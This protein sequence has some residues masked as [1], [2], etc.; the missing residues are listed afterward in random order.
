MNSLQNHTPKQH[1]KAPPLSVGNG[2]FVRA[3]APLGIVT[4]TQV[5]LATQG[6]QRVGDFALQDTSAELLP[7]ERVCGCCRRR[8]DKTKPR[9]VKYNNERKKAH[10]ANVQR[11]GSVWI[12]PVCAKQVTEGRR[13][14]LAVGIERWKKEHSGS[15]QLLTLTFSHHLGERLSVLLQCLRKATKLFLETT[16]V[17]DLMKSAGVKYKIKS[18]EVTYGENGWHPHHHFLLLGTQGMDLSAVRDELAGLWIKACQRAGLKSPNMQHGLDVRNGDYAN[19]YVAKWGLDYEMTKGHTKKAKN[20]YT[21]FDILNLAHHGAMIGDRTAKSLWQEWGVAIKGQRQLVWGRGLKK[22]LGVDE[23]SD[24][25]L[26]LETEKQGEL[27]AEVP[28]FLFMLIEVYKKRAEFLRCIEQDIEQGL[29][30]AGSAEY[31]LMELCQRFQ[32]EPPE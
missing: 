12:C 3:D 26:A 19:K 9:Q 25:E 30:G 29:L 5:T 20:G 13:A 32:Q 7:K 8:I 2:A 22:L 14:E 4:K 11:C 16:R 18:L 23:K 17:K 10:W 27:V 31:L 1:S 15:V 21:P 28:D 6:F 24:E